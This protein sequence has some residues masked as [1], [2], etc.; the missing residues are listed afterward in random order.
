MTEEHRE[1]ASSAA[2]ALIALTA[3]ACSYCGKNTSGECLLE[4]DSLASSCVVGCTGWGA[5]HLPLR[6]EGTRTTLAGF[7]GGDREGVG[8]ISQRRVWAKTGTA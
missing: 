3:A 5:L 4:T 2:S 8:G 6:L 7:S 1:G